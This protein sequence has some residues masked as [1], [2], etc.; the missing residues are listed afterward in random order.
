MNSVARRLLGSQETGLVVVL[1]VVAA[2]AAL[3]ALWHFGD[4]YVQ[5]F[6]ALDIPTDSRDVTLWYNDVGLGYFLYQNPDPSR[7]LTAS[8]RSRGGCALQRSCRPA[9]RSAASRS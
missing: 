1:A 9:V 8:T 4:F 7:F 6:T 5:G 2:V 3:S